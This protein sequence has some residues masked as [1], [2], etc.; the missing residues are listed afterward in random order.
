M[1]QILIVEDELTAVE[2]LIEMITQIEG[3]SGFTVSQSVKETIDILNSGK[4][5]DLGFFDIQL[6]DDISFEIFKSVKIEF[7]IIFTTAYDQYVLKALE[8]NAID[9][10]LKPVKAERLE[11]ALQ[12]I[13][14]LES[15]FIN[16]QVE[17][18]IKNSPGKNRLLVKK[19][20][21]YISIK[22]EDVAYLFTEHKVS[23]LVDKEGTKY[24]IDKPL[25]EL[26]D[27]LGEAE[28]FRINRKYIA[29]IDAIEKFRSDQGKIRVFLS[30]ETN[31]EVM[32]SKETAPKFRSWIEGA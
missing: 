15:H 22:K 7:P 16:Q 6:A 14:T 23:F 5:F 29:H 8:E 13:K 28:F 2:K 19:G 24:I 30:P 17:N 1:K 4:T 20:V 27:Q 32:V 18:I 26:H 11:V 25:S 21:E 10:L 3:E 31:E 9:Y 12:K